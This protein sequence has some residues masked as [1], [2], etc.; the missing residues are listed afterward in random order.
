M[1]F[2]IDIELDD[3]KRH[4]IVG[5]GAFGKVWMVTHKVTK[6]PFALKMVNKRKIIKAKITKMMIREKEIMEMLD[7]PFII[8]LINTYHDE[9]FVY[10]LTKLVQGGELRTLVINGVLKGTQEWGA[11]FYSACVLESMS[12]M[13]SRNIVHR[14][15]KTENIVIDR[16]GYAVIVDFGFA[17]IVREK[18]YTFCGSPQHIAPE[19]I[20]YNGHNKSADYW[21]FG[22]LIYELIVGRNPFYK[23][24]QNQM[25]LVKNIVKRK[26]SFPIA[27]STSKEAKDLIARLLVI[28]PVDRLSNLSPTDRGVREHPWFSQ[29][30]FDE[31]VRQNIQAPWIPD[32]RDPC[33]VSNF[34]NWD[35]MENPWE[36]TKRT[37]PA[38]QQNIFK[39]FGSTDS[40]P[41]TA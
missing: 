37:I 5:A 9:R 25:D 35:N 36:E 26:Y 31:L 24:G 33:D 34:R 41:R 4:H 2:D 1:L 10:M 30:S 22:V 15:L 14:D 17:K 21:S 18:T 23:K 27:N 40:F 38:A 6:A 32:L 20:L 3:L 8:K 19:I 16:H 12:Y 11:K 29:V 39:H 7:H 28:D 13:H